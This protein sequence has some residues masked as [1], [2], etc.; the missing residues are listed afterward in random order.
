MEVRIDKQ[1]EVP[2]HRQVADQIVFLIVTEKLKAGAAL[3]SVRELA[4]RLKIHHNTVSQAYQRLVQDNWLIRRHGARLVVGPARSS[5]SIESAQDLDELINATIRFARAK[6]YSLQTLRQRV[7]ERLLEEPPDH[8][9]VIE[10]DPGLRRLIENEIRDAVRF[11]LKGCSREELV[12]NPGIAIGAIPVAAQHALSQVDA[13]VPKHRPA[14]SVSFAS[15]D[16]HLTVIRNLRAP[17]VIG[18]VSVSEAFMQIARSLLAPALGPRHALKE[19]LNATAVPKG[20]DLVFADSASFDLIKN[21]KIIR[22]QL[23]AE[24]SLE[25]LSNAVRDSR[26]AADSPALRGREKKKVAP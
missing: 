23:L 18:I 9:L 19:F 25:Y 3:P 14:I 1:S 24:E 21:P 15:A 4:R 6:G 26:Q 17:S 22:Y 12:A 5:G 20:L 8:I 7:R 16:K 13:L 2:V 11:P 10:Q